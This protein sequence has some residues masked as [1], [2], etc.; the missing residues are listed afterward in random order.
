MSHLNEERLSAYMDGALPAAEMAAAD[1]H[2]AG[3]EACRATLETLGA[4]D[5][6]F[7]E[8]LTHDP[9]DAYF[10]TFAARVQDRI[11]AEGATRPAAAAAIT[12]PAGEVVGTD[13]IEARPP[14]MGAPWWDV[15]SWF[16]VP[17]RLAW[18]GG[19]AAVVVVAGVT[20][21]L[22]RENGVPDLRDAKVRERSAQLESRPGEPPPPAT[23][24][25]P[26]GAG[27]G[28]GGKSSE[29]AP[30]AGD[31]AARMATPSRVR[32]M[33]QVPGGE[34]VPVGGR[35][36]PDFARAP[37]PAPV[38]ERPGEPKTVRRP[39]R[40][41]P[42]AATAKGEADAAKDEARAPAPA[43]QDA[44]T[45]A[46]AA[47]RAVSN[48]GATGTAER[49]SIAERLRLGGAAAACGT[50]VD[51]QGR[52]LARA[53]VVLGDR[54]TTATTGEDGRFCFD[55]APG[56]YDLTVLAVGFTPLRQRVVLGDPNAPARLVARTVDVLP[57]PQGP[58][59]PAP[60]SLLPPPL[61]EFRDGLSS[62]PAVP[63]GL[64]EALRP[65]WEEAGRVMTEARAGRSATR[66]A[67]AA[68]VWRELIA[69]I[70]DDALRLS[71]RE[72]RADALYAAWEI[73]PTGARVAAAAAALREV[74]QHAPEGPQRDRARRMLARLQP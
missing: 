60:A 70:P 30:P 9:G 21:M 14:R 31:D 27:A 73:E 32:E 61:S 57:A 43:T 35:E 3:C 69:R 51:E 41:E 40:V 5:A 4:A 29:A 72:H 8:A 49:E 37:A 55:V 11:G 56:E 16:T 26:E 67:E 12:E 18:V 52:P 34:D 17:Q 2:L 53:Q 46:D 25:A 63:A 45:D 15:G 20:M 65:R 13:V 7:G 1:T 68:E 33:R 64:P 54:G 42:L 24:Q 66:Y 6:L 19:V 58:A 50:V 59:P 47:K 39:Q 38:E 48:L 10:A 22:V 74:I 28:A 23:M 36:I 62:A 44:R 71:T